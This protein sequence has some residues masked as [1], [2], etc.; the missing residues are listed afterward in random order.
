VT[1]ATDVI[2]TLLTGDAT[3]SALLTGG[4]HNVVELSR[5]SVP[6]AFDAN[7]EIEPCANVRVDTVT[8]D[9]VVGF[10]AT[11]SVAVWLYE[12]GIDGA[13]IESARSRIYELLHRA[14]VGSGSFELWH[15]N[16]V[17]GFY[18]D[19]LSATTIVSR[20]EVVKRR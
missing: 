5:Q 19:G 13:T 3:L 4:V 14:R 7:K 10:A 8:G 1:T 16:D 12:R 9:R 11:E 17:T 20:Y 15:T 18:D 2:T 6:D